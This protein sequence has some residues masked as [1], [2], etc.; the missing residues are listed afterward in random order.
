MTQKKCILLLAAVLV[1]F[2]APAC[3]G[4]DMQEGSWEI[5]IVSEMSGSAFQMPAQTHTQCLSKADMI[6]KDPKAPQNCDIIEQ[7]ISGNTVNWI[8]ECSEG[9]VKT[10]SKGSITY[11]GDSFSGRM[12]VAIGGTSMKIASTMTGRRLGP[13][14]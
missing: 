6:P 2:A 11:G 1:L 5:T 9:G 4:P 7:R 10:V 14:K 12:D 3:A 13:C 8:M